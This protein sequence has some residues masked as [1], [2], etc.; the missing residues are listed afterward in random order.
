MS[1]D[2]SLNIALISSSFS[3]SWKAL[4]LHITGGRSPNVTF[5]DGFLADRNCNKL[6]QACQN[7]KQT[8]MPVENKV[9]TS[10]AP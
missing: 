9:M 3:I 2:D 6:N 7:E 4:S 8:Y 5:P 1:E 10:N